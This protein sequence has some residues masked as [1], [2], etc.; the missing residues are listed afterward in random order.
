[1]FTGGGEEEKG[2]EAQSNPR[3]GKEDPEWVD[4]LPGGRGA[5]GSEITGKTGQKPQLGRTPPNKGVGRLQGGQGK[6][7]YWIRRREM[8]RGK[9]KVTRVKRIELG[10]EV[11]GASPGPVPPCCSNPNPN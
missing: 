7:G 5:D 10:T 8:Q 6:R 4:I 2:G 3:L 9:A 11:E 1:M